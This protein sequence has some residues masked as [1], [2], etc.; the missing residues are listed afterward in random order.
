MSLI[1]LLAIG[2]SFEAAKSEPYRFNKKRQS[3]LPK[4]T[5]KS[6][7]TPTA[8]KPLVPDRVKRQ[9]DKARQGLIATVK[10][11][12][13]STGAL[14]LVP[15]AELEQ[16]ARSGSSGS[17]VQ[18]EF[19]LDRLKVV[20]NDLTES[21]LEVVPANSEPQTSAPTSALVEASRG[22]RFGAGWFRRVSNLLAAARALF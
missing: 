16:R 20:R 8:A 12:K 13:Q 2:H 3:L 7:A 6:T 10:V 14:M 22:R 5:A 4:F 19:S 17:T 21:D 15:T 11:G 1:R 9:K 18:I